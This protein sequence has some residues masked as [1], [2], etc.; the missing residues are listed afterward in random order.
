MR[1]LLRIGYNLQNTYS[2]GHSS[3][4]L[5]FGF[6]LVPGVI[7]ILIEYVLQSGY[8]FLTKFDWNGSYIHTKGLND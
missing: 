3:V 6:L 7:Q 2:V 5:F 4:L 1:M 8:T